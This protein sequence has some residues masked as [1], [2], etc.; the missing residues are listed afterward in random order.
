MRHSSAWVM[1]LF[2]LFAETPAFAQQEFQAVQPESRIARQGSNFDRLSTLRREV[3]VSQAQVGQGAAP[4]RQNSSLGQPQRAAT[5]V[6][7]PRSDDPAHIFPGDASQ[8]GPQQECPTAQESHL[9]T[10][11]V[12]GP[13]RRHQHRRCEDE[14]R[15]ISRENSPLSGRQ[16]SDR[17]HA[18]GS[19][20]EFG[21]RMTNHV[22]ECLRVGRRNIERLHRADGEPSRWREMLTIGLRS[23]GRIDPRDQ[24]G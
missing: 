16:I 5:T 9:G 8:P 13:W 23:V 20:R 7:Y 3:T 6:G 15:P 4:Q 10:R 19:C 1:F 14:F 11:R 18:I 12:F 21:S 17:S 22:G 2:A 24:L